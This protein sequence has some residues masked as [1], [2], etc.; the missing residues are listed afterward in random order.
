MPGSSPAECRTALAAH[1]QQAPTLEITFCI[2]VH[3]AP[4]LRAAI[5]EVRGLVGARLEGASRHAR[6]AALTRAAVAIAALH[7]AINAKVP[8]EDPDYV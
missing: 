8:V 1:R 4:A 3:T 5:N 7:A 2:P 6:E